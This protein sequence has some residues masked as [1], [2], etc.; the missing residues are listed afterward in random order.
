MPT[1]NDSQ[2]VPQLLPDG[3]YIFCVADFEIGLSTG[4]KTNGCEKYEVE[5]EIEPSGKKVLEFMVDHP[6]CAWKIDTFLKSCGVK[7]TKGE[8]FD[9]REDVAKEKGIR[10]VNP[11]GLR[12]W[13]CLK[14]E[15]SSKD[16]K[17][18]FNKVAIFYT[19]KTKLEARLANAV[20]EEDVP[21]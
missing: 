6:T 2:N 15:P 12:G 7:L 1:F 17:K 5:L 11:I 20:S 14:S 19:E 8:S 13:C 16:P 18:I 21:F 9:F 4:G 10:W 3:D